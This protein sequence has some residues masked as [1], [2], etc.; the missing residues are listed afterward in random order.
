MHKSGQWKGKV[1]FASFLLHHLWTSIG[2]LFL[3]VF[4]WILK[5]DCS[6]GNLQNDMKSISFF[7]EY[8]CH[9]NITCHLVS[10]YIS[11]RRYLY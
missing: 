4:G 10:Y 3:N 5:F 6:I 1:F 2:V 7:L 11:F 8:F 9:R